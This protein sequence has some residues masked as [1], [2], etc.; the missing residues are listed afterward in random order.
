LEAA[1][2]RVF[3]AKFAAYHFFG[4][5]SLAGLIRGIGISD[6]NWNKTLGWSEFLLK[7]AAF[8]S[9]LNF[10]SSDAFYAGIDD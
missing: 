5:L 4:G 1:G 3:K 10:V 7:E 6:W 9:N 2:W 8:A